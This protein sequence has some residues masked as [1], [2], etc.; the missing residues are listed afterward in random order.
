MVK[1]RKSQRFEDRD[2]YAKKKP[3]FRG[4][5]WLSEEKANVS[6]TEVVKQRKSQ[7]I[8]DRGG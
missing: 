8:E 2:G 1:R 5:R 4:Q 7:R 6:R 3:T